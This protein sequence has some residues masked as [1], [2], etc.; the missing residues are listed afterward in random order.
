MCSEKTTLARMLSPVADIHPRH[1]LKSETIGGKYMKIDKKTVDM[2]STLPDDALWRVIC[3][4]CAGNGL[5][6]SGVKVT[7][8]ELDKVR[9]ALCSLTDDDIARAVEILDNFKNQK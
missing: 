6:L 8:V 3:S 5:D 4:L 1:I 7:G 9:S 2:L